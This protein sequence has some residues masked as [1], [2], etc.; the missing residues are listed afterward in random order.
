MQEKIKV[1]TKEVKKMAGKNIVQ[2]YSAR[3]QCFILNIGPS[4]HVYSDH[5]CCCTNTLMTIKM[6]LKLLVE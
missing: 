3:V 4:D 6:E 1:D 2:Q 5:V